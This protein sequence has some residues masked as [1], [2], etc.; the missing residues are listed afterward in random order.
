MSTVDTHINWAASYLV[1]DVY[2]RFLRPRASQKQLVLVSRLSVVFISLFSVL[3]ASQITSIE[4][5]WKIFI[6]LGAGMGLPQILRWVWWRVNA[7]TEIAGMVTAFCMSVFLY[8]AFPAVKDEYLL[9]WIVITSVSASI[10]V[11]VL[12]KPVENEVLRQ[13]TARVKPFGFW[14]EMVFEKQINLHIIKNRIIMWILGVTTTFCGMFS[15]GY[16]LRGPRATGII[17]FVVS[18]VCFWLVIRLMSEQTN[19]L[20]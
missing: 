18:G 8:L 19:E 17:C 15:I 13:F 1:N 20:D 14:K 4:K 11:T 12:T 6:A 7:W 9:V 16:F 10:T 3:V 2:K 5:A